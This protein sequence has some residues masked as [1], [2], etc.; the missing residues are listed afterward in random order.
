VKRQPVA[1]VA[2]G[3]AGPVG[4]IAGFV[5]AILVVVTLAF[6]LVDIAHNG[7][8]PRPSVSP[9]KSETRPAP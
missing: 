8:G 9:G 7:L 2:Q 4:S 1:K 3:I 6:G 5:V